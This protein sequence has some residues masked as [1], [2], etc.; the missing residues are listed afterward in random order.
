MNKEQET[1]QE[2]KQLFNLQFVTGQIK[3]LETAGRMVSLYR[4]IELAFYDAA[5]FRR[6]P[7][8]VATEP[9]EMPT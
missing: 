9:D 4:E 7:K 3:N 1:L 8:P 6:L 2:L 5:Q